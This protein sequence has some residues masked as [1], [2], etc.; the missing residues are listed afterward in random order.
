MSSGI[1]EGK[2]GTIEKALDSEGVCEDS[3][4]ALAPAVVGKQEILS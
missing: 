4:G 1:W 2:R 3:A